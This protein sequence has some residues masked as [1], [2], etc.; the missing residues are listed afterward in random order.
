MF[1]QN[2]YRKFIVAVICI[3]NPIVTSTFLL[4]SHTNLDEMFFNS[5]L[6]SII[7]SAM[8]AGLFSKLIT[9]ENNVTEKNDRLHY[10]AWLLR[11]VTQKYPDAVLAGLGDK[12]KDLI[13][14]F[15][16]QN[17]LQ[18]S[19][20]ETLQ[21]VDDQEVRAIMRKIATQKHHME[22]LVEVAEATGLVMPKGWK[23]S[24]LAV[25]AKA[26]QTEV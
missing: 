26:A 13:N 14:L 3:I 4:K 10:Y 7:I 12:A 23:Y 11:L 2:N 21:K 17:T 1:T 25:M 16:E 19:S 20:N 15:A 5:I 6:F 8:I 22:C 24:D 18:Q 9:F